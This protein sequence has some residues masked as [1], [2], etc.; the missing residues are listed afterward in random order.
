MEQMFSTYKIMSAHPCKELQDKTLEDLCLEYNQTTNMKLKNNIYRTMYCKLFP[1]MLN[2]QKNYPTLTN[3]QK[4]E[5]T[6]FILISTLR[7]YKGI[8]KERTKFSTYYCTNLKNGMVTVINSM[9]CHKRCV[10]MNMID[11]AE[12]VSYVLSTQ[13]DKEKETT[14]NYFL[15][16]LKSAKYLSTLEKEYCGCV[17]AGYTKLDELSELLDLNNRETIYDKKKTVKRKAR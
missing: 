9:K 1:M 7:C 14:N 8:E 17:L 4:V 10:W 15:D 13:K 12:T 16:N 5:V 6:M 11:N 3:E 2:V